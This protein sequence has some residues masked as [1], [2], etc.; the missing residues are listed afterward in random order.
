MV[1]QTLILVGVLAV[2]T[3]TAGAEEPE[4]PIVVA[5]PLDERV[6]V[7]DGWSYHPGDDPGWA[8]PDLDDR[9]WPLISSYLR[10]PDSVPGG[11]PG[12]G[13]FR[14]RVVLAEG[15]PMTAL[16]VRVEQAG[17]AEVYLDGELVV[18]FGTVSASREEEEPFYPNHFD[19]L[20]LEP[21]VTHVLAVR[22]SNINDNVIYGDVHGFQVNL[23][24]VAGAAKAYL[25]WTLMVT[26][27]P[28]AFFGAFAALAVLHLLLFLF[29]PQR[30]ENLYFTIFIS[31]VAVSW[32]LGTKLQ[33]TPDTMSALE[34]KRQLIAAMVAS[35]LTGLAVVHVL[36]RRR[37]DLLTWIIGA[38]GIILVAW[39]WSL[40][41]L[42]PFTISQV[43][44]FIGY[45]EMLR[46]TVMAMRRREPDAWIIAAGMIPKAGL[47]LVAQGMRLFANS[48]PSILP[49]AITNILLVLAFSVYLSRRTARTSRE[50]KLRLIEVE[51][52]SQRA[53]EQERQA[54]EERSER[55]LVEAE[56]QRRNS[57]LQE[58]RRLQLAMLPRQAPTIAGLDM[59]FRMVTATEVGGDYVDI[60]AA[61]PN[62]ALVAVGD[63]TSHGLHAGMVVAVAKSLF[64]GV[65]LQEQP[66]AVL[67]RI[68]AGL[69]EMQERYASMAVVV[70]RIGDGQLQIASAA[71]PPLLILRAGTTQVEEVMLPGVPLGTMTDASY[72]QR[73]IAIAP[74]D[75]LLLMSDG[76]VEAMNPEQQQFGYERVSQRL[77]CLGGATAEEVVD[78]MLAEVTSFLA[79][80]TPQDDITIVAL[81]VGK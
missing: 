5:P 73:Q 46:V 20:V 43:Y 9:D 56:N 66:V 8:D 26:V 58:A 59:A 52:L 50:L 27:I 6:A 47:V 22:Y 1:V 12:I 10:D 3:G 72:Q 48:S 39:Y 55:R 4:Q 64:H 69:Q 45:A 34:V 33:L 36:F 14:R 49:T 61:S 70:L 41:A 18:S 31:T 62:G 17:A 29:H 76:L 35:I 28:M 38:A 63:A 21:G 67:Q 65:D 54:A 51:E 57:E 23:R 40:P 44:F 7:R 78:A 37:P 68:D 25:G 30:R 15:L 79:G 74:G 11:W 77:A 19:G 24:G 13:W 32:A 42:R 80:V 60:R 75:T 2:S 81:V 53:I 16:A 71:M